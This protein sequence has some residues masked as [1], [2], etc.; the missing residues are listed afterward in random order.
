MGCPGDRLN[1]EWETERVKLQWVPCSG[2][3][4]RQDTEK[5]KQRINLSLFTLYSQTRKP[6]P[7]ATRGSRGQ[8]WKLG[9]TSGSF[10]TI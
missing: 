10:K 2:E 8:E 1:E 7:A 6:K 3:Q 5:E 9:S 4:T